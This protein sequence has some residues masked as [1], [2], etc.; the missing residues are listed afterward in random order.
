MESLAIA[1]LI[2]SL[3]TGLS[4][5]IFFGVPPPLQPVEGGDSVKSYLLTK[6]PNRSSFRKSTLLFLTAFIN[7]WCL[8]LTI[9]INGCSGL[10][11]HF[12]KRLILLFNRFYKRV[13]N[14]RRGYAGFQPLCQGVAVVLCGGKPPLLRGFLITLQNTGYHRLATT[15]DIS[16]L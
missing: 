4:H 2:L 12:H 1:L 11:S 3:L 9:S 13:S 6:N 14:P 16:F 5:L 10:K 8:Y 7:G 15:S